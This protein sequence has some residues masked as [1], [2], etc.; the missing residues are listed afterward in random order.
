MLT[1]P[2]R[3]RP[4]ASKV[5]QG[6]SRGDSLVSPDTLDSAMLRE[7]AVPQ[8]TDALKAEQQWHRLAMELRQYRD[9]QV[10]DWQGVDEALI[11]KH[12]LGSCNDDDRQK[13]Q[14]ALQDPAGKVARCL[15]MLEEI[16]TD[17]SPIAPPEPRPLGR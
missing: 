13:I 8:R 3:K 9:S 2:E 7:L 16:L 10:R 17:P 14:S 12:F 5:D 6:T 11:A 15:N 1:G 4:E